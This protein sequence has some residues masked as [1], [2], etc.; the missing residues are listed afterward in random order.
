MPYFSCNSRYSIRLVFFFSLRIF[1]IL[2]VLSTGA[3]EN[4]I[5]VLSV[6]LL[7]VGLSSVLIVEVF[8]DFCTL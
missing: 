8:L 3:V 6:I 2:P 1:Y 7:Y 4:F 5:L